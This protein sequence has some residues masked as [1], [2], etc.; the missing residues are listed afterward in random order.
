[1]LV[2]V[3]VVYVPVVYVPSYMYQSYMYQSYMY[4]SYMY[5]SPETV[6]RIWSTK[7]NKDNV[8]FSP[9]QYHTSSVKTE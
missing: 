7:N 9:S 6:L 4:K 5:Q 2:Y 8:P 3:P 1:M